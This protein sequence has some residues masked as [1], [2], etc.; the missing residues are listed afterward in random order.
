MPAA[1]A[2][3]GRS[4]SLVLIGVCTLVYF[5]DGVIH[6]ILGPLAPDI[7]RSLA[8]G[9]TQLGPIFSAN[10][11]G[12]CVGLVLFPLLALRTGQRK[13][14]LLALIG[15]GLAQCA[16]AASSSATELFV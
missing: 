8:L 16:T 9:N 2:K 6:S 11:V 10:L 1:V 5:L 13:V 3:S 14:V 12:Q 7:A 15:F 4:A